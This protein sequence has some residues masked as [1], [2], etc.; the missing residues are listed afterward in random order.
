MQ[1]QIQSRKSAA[2]WN[3]VPKPSQRMPL[4]LAV[5]FMGFARTRKAIV[6]T[7]KAMS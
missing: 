5:D 4:E 2:Q 6:N 1:P 7:S 3:R